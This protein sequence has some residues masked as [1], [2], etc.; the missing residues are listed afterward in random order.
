MCGH[1]TVCMCVCVYCCGAQ[2]FTCRHYTYHSVCVCVCVCVCVLG[3]GVHTELCVAAVVCVVVG[4][5]RYITPRSPGLW[6]QRKLG[7]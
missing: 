5:M 2:K 7:V 3:I 4:S 1:D 6:Y